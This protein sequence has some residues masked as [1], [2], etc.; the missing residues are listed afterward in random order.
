M[1]ITALNVAQLGLNFAA[2]TG[3]ELRDAGIGQAL[4]SA[5]R[6][7][8][9]W[10][11]TAYGYLLEYLATRPGSFRGEQVRGFAH[12]RGC[13]LPAHLRAWGGVLVRAAN[14]GLIEKVGTGP[15]LNPIAH[16]AYANIWRRVVR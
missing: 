12:A 1:N 10:S 7:M 9:Q 2:P 11:E 14:R 15:V 4:A 13:P 8:P 5:E 3:R 6:Q 16:C